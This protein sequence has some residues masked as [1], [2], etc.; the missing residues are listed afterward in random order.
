[1]SAHTHT[2]ELIIVCI[3][4]IFNAFWNKLDL[5]NELDDILTL[6]IST[7]SSDFF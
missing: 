2:N 6:L 4:C 3:N 5:D 1:M 7:W